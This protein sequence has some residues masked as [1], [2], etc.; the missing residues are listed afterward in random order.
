MSVVT[1]VILKTGL[2]EELGVQQVNERLS[3]LDSHHSPFVSC[4]DTRKGMRSY[5]GSKA[6]EIDLYPG[7]FNHLHLQDLLDSIR[8]AHWDEP[9]EVQLFVQGETDTRLREVECFPK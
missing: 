5:A 2:Q 8:A 7:A 9:E 4:D 6:L 3:S 1:N